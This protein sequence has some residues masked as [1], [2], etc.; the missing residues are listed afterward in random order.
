M[1]TVKGFFFILWWMII[2]RHLKSR[3]TVGIKIDQIA[4]ASLAT[5]RNLVAR[6]ATCRFFSSPLSHQQAQRKTYRRGF[7]KGSPSDNC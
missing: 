3:S 1:Y 7:K 4:V 5:A 6:L 2:G